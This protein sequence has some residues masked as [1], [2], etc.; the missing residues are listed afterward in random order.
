MKEVMQAMVPLR[1]T[2]NPIN[3]CQIEI[4]E[5]LRNLR[6]AS[7]ESAIESPCRRV[8]LIILLVMR[9]ASSL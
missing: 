3:Q 2:T 9:D 6:F 8:N 5:V 4:A 1:P 7:C